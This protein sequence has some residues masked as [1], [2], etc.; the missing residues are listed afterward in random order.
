[1]PESASQKIDRRFESEVARR[2]SIAYNNQFLI[3]NSPSVQQNPGADNFEGIL[4]LLDTIS[5]YKY[6]WPDSKKE[7]P[8]GPGISAG[9]LRS[10]IDFLKLH[11]NINYPSISL[12]P[13]YNIYAS[14]RDEQNR[15]FSV[16]FLSNGGARF[17]IFKPNY[18]HPERKIRI[19]GTTTTDIL[20]ETVSPHEIT[21]WVLE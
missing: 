15:V 4:Q 9:S 14:W 20:M 5:R 16:H 17:V 6:D 21:D 3:D 10:F 7:D 11:L 2:A 12:T 18:R 13:E 8:Y 19:S 1:M